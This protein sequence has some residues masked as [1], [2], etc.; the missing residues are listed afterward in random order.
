MAGGVCQT[1]MQA[2]RHGVERVGLP[3][4]CVDSCEQLAGML[5]SPYGWQLVISHCF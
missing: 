1:A 5:A 2:F 4:D 3:A